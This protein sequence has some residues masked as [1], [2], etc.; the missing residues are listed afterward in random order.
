ME[1]R[2]KD[3]SLKETSGRVENFERWFQ[4]HSITQNDDGEYECRASNSHG[5]VKHVFTV[6]V[7]GRTAMIGPHTQRETQ[8][9]CHMVLVFV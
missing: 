3:G 4:F 9:Q 2:K 1:W 6:S 5:S 8:E 7:E